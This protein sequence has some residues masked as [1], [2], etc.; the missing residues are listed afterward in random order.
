[1]EIRIQQYIIIPRNPIVW[2]EKKK[3]TN[4]HERLTFETDVIVLNWGTDLNLTAEK[5]KPVTVRRKVKP[6]PFTRFW[7]KA[8]SFWVQFQFVREVKWLTDVTESKMC[9]Y[10]ISLKLLLEHLGYYGNWT[11]TTTTNVIGCQRSDLIM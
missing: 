6:E 8:L 7:M 4:D 11:I 1:M 3:K 9:N 2:A 5:K 10:I